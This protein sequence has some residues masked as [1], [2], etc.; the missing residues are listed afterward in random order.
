MKHLILTS[1][2]ST[3]FYFGQALAEDTLDLEPSINGEVSASGLY[4]TQAEEDHALAMLSEP[5]IFGDEIPPPSSYVARI[6]KNMEL[7]RRVARIG[8]ESVNRVGPDVIGG[9]Y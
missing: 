8:K 7:E 1:F 2:F 9:G 3:A 6:Q 4:P 5:C